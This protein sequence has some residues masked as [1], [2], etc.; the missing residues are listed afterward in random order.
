MNPDFSLIKDK[1]VSLF[2]LY[3]KYTSPLP[4]RHPLYEDFVLHKQSTGQN[5][6]GYTRS[7]YLGFV[8]LNDEVLQPQFASMNQKIV[9]FFRSL[10]PRL[11]KEYDIM[12]NCHYFRSY[13]TKDMRPIFKD[14][15]FTNSKKEDLKVTLCLKQ[16]DIKIPDKD[17]STKSESG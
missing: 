6:S 17:S 12:W 4:P 10:D 14:K 3:F 16:N 7:D 13:L 5:N 9:Y 2:D 8:T 11:T 1:H 15:M